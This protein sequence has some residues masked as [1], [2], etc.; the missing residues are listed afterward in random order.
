MPKQRRTLL[1]LNITREQY[2]QIHALATAQGFRYVSDYVRYVLEQDAR[3]HGV[4]V[5]LKALRSRGRPRKNERE[6]E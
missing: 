6:E 4:A 1:A 2:N 3:A 5:S